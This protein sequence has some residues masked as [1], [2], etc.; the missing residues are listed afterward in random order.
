MMAWCLDILRQ[1]GKLEFVG[2]G[3]LNDEGINRAIEFVDSYFA[4]DSVLL[5][6]DFLS[7]P[8]HE[9][10]VD[11]FMELRSIRDGVEVPEQ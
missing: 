4:R 8:N 6:S 7:L 9:E 10:L 1:I 5:G 11:I 2:D 3:P